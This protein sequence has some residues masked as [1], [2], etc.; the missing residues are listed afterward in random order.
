MRKRVFA[1]NHEYPYIRADQIIED[2]YV[3]INVDVYLSNY[4]CTYVPDVMIL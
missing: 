4:V 3:N 1:E 2:R